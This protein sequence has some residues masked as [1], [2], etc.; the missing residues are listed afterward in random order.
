MRAT[1]QRRPPE[2]ELVTRILDVLP[3]TDRVFHDLRLTEPLV[4]ALVQRVRRLRTAG[5]ILIVAPNITLTRALLELGYQV[6]LWQVDG[7]TLTDDLA[8][9]VVDRALLDA[10]LAR[11]ADADRYDVIILPYVLEAAA[12]HP[13]HVMDALRQRLHPGGAL[14]LAYRQAGSL[15]NRIRGAAGRPTLP[16]PVFG[17]N[18][19]SFSWPAPPARRTFGPSQLRGWARRTGVPV[20][21]HD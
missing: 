6:E 15:S 18:G 11:P 17:S 2:G 7:G 20:V 12:Q 5:R 3:V 19:M 14:L 1:V 9:L 21:E 8:E 4:L 16:D 13:A 10:L